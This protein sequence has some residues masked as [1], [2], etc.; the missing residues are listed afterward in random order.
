M[1]VSIIG[2]LFLIVFVN[3]HEDEA[4][5]FTYRVADK[6]PTIMVWVVY[7]AILALVAGFYFLPS[8]IAFRRNHLNAVAILALNLFL[9]WSLIGW[10]V[11][12]VWS[13][14]RTGPQRPA[15]G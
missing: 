10:V 2:A 14:L 6:L 15:I 9:G 4:R 12:L 13:L 8:I 11:S 7:L 1:G 5:D 3:S